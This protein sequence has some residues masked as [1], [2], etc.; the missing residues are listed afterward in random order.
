VFSLYLWFPLH[1]PLK[2]W[3]KHNGISTHTLAFNA[4]AYREIVLRIS[5][6]IEH[7]AR[8]LEQI[9]RDLI[10]TLV[11][12]VERSPRLVFLYLATLVEIPVFIATLAETTILRAR[13][14]RKSRSV[15]T[16]DQTKQ[17]SHDYSLSNCDPW[18]QARASYPGGCKGQCARCL[19]ATF[20]FYLS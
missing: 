14:S 10:W 20:S 15:K 18:P 6:T 16:L 8:R 5:D 19:S 9:W 1:F 4:Y 3:S 7:L 2:E 12:S 17:K 11:Y 13:S